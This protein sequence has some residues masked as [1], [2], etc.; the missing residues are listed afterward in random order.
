[1]PDPVSSTDAELFGSVLALTQ[2]LTLRV[3]KQLAPF[4]LTSRQWLLLAV[5]AKRFPGHAPTVSE[6]TAVFGTSRQNVKQIALQLERRGWLRLEPDA[7]DHRAL[8]LML[9]DRI[10]VFDEPAVRGEQAAFIRSVFGGLTPGERRTF[11]GLVTACIGRMANLAPGEG[12][13]P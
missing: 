12:G 1:M 9:T 7:T 8:R 13:S 3:E 10:S 5:L 2:Q 6:A 11:L 4:G